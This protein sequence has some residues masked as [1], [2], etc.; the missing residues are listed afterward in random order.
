M[1]FSEEEVTAAGFT[2]TSKLPHELASYE[3]T[4]PNGASVALNRPGLGKS[5]HSAVEFAQTPALR[6]AKIYRFTT[7]AELQQLAAG[8]LAPFYIF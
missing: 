8:T 2:K 1:V 5:H 4:L 3:T 6:A 7:V